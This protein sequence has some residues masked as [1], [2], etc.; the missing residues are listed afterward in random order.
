MNGTLGKPAG[1]AG[2]VSGG[3]PPMKGPGVCL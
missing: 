2:A 1:P 3:L